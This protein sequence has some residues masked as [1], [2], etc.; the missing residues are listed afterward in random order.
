MSD[1]VVVAGGGPVGLAVALGLA[2]R[3]RLPVCVVER[4]AVPQWTPVDAYD[5]RV[6]ALSPASLDLLTA[7]GVELDTSRM[8]PVH[9]MQVWGDRTD[10]PLTLQRGMPLAA[11]V[12]HGALMQALHAAAAGAIEI[13]H[14]QEIRRRSSG[15]VELSQGD[16][17]DAGLLVAAEG[18]DSP[19]REA[20]GIAVDRVDYRAMGVVA[21]FACEAAHG[22]IARQWFRGDSVLALLPLPGRRVSM[23]WSMPNAAAHAVDGL[24]PEELAGRVRDACHGALGSMQAL[25]PPVAFPLA[26]VTAQ[27]WV[28]PGFV[29]AGD[30]AH[31]VHP[32]AGQGVNL[33]FGD[34]AALADILG[35][36]SRFSGIGD[37][38]VLRR[39]ARQRREAAWL[40]G[41]LTDRLQRLF[42]APGESEAW[43]RN[44]GL[45]WL[46]RM[47]RAKSAL[48][49]A[50]VR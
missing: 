45:G 10:A 7:L 24:S 34:A 49:A 14:G 36:R 29:L 31:T 33:G 23:V 15:A 48:I 39:Y 41:E 47:P 16:V 9:A 22:D 1:R 21:N 13:R 40:V 44:R 25:T 5:A 28:Q 8:A 18:R 32:L 30:A 42:I 26:R 38:A 19:L 20:A 50:A 12:E 2:R 4:S 3:A 27:H 6:Y 43:W 35:H 11:I 37:L 17:L 46:D